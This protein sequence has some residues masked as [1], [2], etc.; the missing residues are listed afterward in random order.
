MLTTCAIANRYWDAGAD[1]IYA[2][3]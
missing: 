3:N 1:G 2:F